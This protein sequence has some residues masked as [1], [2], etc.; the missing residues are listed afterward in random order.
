MI[1]YLLDNFSWLLLAMSVTAVVVFVCL[2]FV[3]AGYGKFYTKRWG[4]SV[5]NKMGWVLMEAPVFVLMLVFYFIWEAPV[6]GCRAQDCSH[7][8]PDSNVGSPVLLLF[9]CLFEL[10]YFHRSF[11]FPFLLKGKSRMP[12]A[13]VLLGVVFNSLNAFMQA[14]WLFCLSKNV[15]PYRYTTAWLTTPQFIIG[16]LMFIAGMAININS[17]YIIRQLRAKR[18]GDESNRHYLPDRGLYRHVTSANYFGEF[19]EWC[20]FAV[21]TWS[22]SGAVFALWTFANL[23]PRAHR[24]Y[25]RYQKEFPDQMAARPRKRLIPY[26]WILLLPL[27]ATSSANA[28]ETMPT[29]KEYLPYGR[30]ESWSVRFIKESA[31]IG[32][33]TKCIYNIGPRDTIRENKAYPYNNR[34]PWSSSNAYAKVAGVTKTSCSVVPDRSWDGSLCAKLETKIEELK[35][36]GINIRILVSGS[37]FYGNIFEPIPT[38]N[39]PYSLMNWGMPFT[40]RPQALVFDYKSAM[41]NKGTITRCKIKSQK[42]VSGD[43]AHEV[44]FVLQK[45]WE[46]KDGN[47]HA[48]RVGTAMT[49]IEQPSTGWV[50]NFRVPVVYGNASLKP[51]Y[52]DYM[53][54][55]PKGLTYYAKNSKGKVVEI[56]EEGWAKSD[57]TPTHA[58]VIFTASI[59]EAFVGTLGNTLWLDNIA[60]EY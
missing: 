44:T 36:L 40:K 21:L 38:A 35:V 23:A 47:I 57:E 48:L 11:I 25:K 55:G 22:L 54:L 27:V 50:K 37:I 2:F 53:R 34:T 58:L 7:L 16:T 56:K 31:I 12:L 5:G 28:Q 13:I 46:D 33:N 39:N 45:R 49:R 42:T 18:K 14:G 8:A 51:G 41:P 9:L 4:P 59:H 32:G 29:K 19:V 10:H 17:D 20:G 43:D 6:A 15:M 26:L 3:D 24:I 30:F 1:Q 52:K 60:L